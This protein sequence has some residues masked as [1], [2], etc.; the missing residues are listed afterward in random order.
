MDKIELDEQEK[1]ILD[2]FERGE[3]KRAENLE[4]KH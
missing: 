4:I 3:F 2:S 1:D